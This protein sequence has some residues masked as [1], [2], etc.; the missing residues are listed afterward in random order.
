MDKKSEISTDQEMNR[1]DL[2]KCE[3]ISYMLM[4]NGYKFPEFKELSKHTFSLIEEKING[5]QVL[6]VLDSSHIPIYKRKKDCNGNWLRFEYVCDFT[7][8]SNREILVKDQDIR[9]VVD[10]FL[11][12]LEKEQL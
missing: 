11:S 2:N 6:M 10:A 3:S 1:I 4:A 8:L 12:Q 9:T 5:I 7:N